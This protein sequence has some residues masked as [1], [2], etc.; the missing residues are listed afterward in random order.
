MAQT[1]LE[2]LLVRNRVV[3]KKTQRRPTNII[4]LEKELRHFYLWIINKCV[5]GRIKILSRTPVCFINWM[6]NVNCSLH[7]RVT[8]IM[9]MKSECCQIF[10][11]ILSDSNK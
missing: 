5:T 3:G 4:D 1:V 8:F 6:H 2:Q 7:I 10:G 11:G 9:L